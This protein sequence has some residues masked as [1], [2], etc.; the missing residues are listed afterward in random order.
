MQEVKNTYREE[1]QKEV[2]QLL[3]KLN[4][5]G[6]K[7]CVI[8]K[9]C[10]VS[11]SRVHD[12]KDKQT[13][14]PESLRMLQALANKRLEGSENAKVLRVAKG[15]KLA[16]NQNWQEA[17]LV[18]AITGI[19]S[20]APLSHVQAT[21]LGSVKDL[22]GLNQLINEEAEC[23]IAVEV[24][25]ELAHKPIDIFNL[26]YKNF[27]NNQWVVLPS[28]YQE[29]AVT[30]LADLASCTE[31]VEQ[32]YLKLKQK[33]EQEHQYQARLIAD[34]FNQSVQQYRYHGE[35]IESVLKKVREEALSACNSIF[36]D[37]RRYGSRCSYSLSNLLKIMSFASTYVYDSKY[38]GLVDLP[39]SHQVELYGEVLDVPDDIVVF[40]DYEKAIMDAKAL[41]MVLEK[42]IGW[43][44]ARYDEIKLT[45]L[46]R[47]GLSKKLSVEK[48]FKEQECQR[49]ISGDLISVSEFIDF[50]AVAELLF[51]R[52]GRKQTL[53]YAGEEHEVD[54]VELLSEWFKPATP[55]VAF[56][57][58]QVPDNLV[59]PS[60]YDEDTSFSVF[61][62]VE[63]NLLV[64]FEQREVLGIQAYV[65]KKDL[66]AFEVVEGISEQ[67]L[68]ESVKMALLEHS[69]VFDDVEVIN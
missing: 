47:L 38:R 62:I 63:K 37:I 6:I 27:I 29:K 3:N 59:Y 51:N 55:G 25:K 53:V 40:E 61:R 67:G 56:K 39:S 24:D 42:F 26:K 44:Q 33:K 14:K 57:L 49:L 8:A 13:P 36:E 4:E 12:W 54:L 7:D 22:A 30:L 19:L 65:M 52:N 28:N 64:T 9:K 2:V 1:K 10:G 58:V 43:Q 60:T 5:R 11:P 34:A 15:I 31:E 50:S 45:V 23:Y 48:L 21:R 68:R 16:L 66:C 20:K 35:D 17:F 32:D 41:Y 46:E 69:Y 18:E